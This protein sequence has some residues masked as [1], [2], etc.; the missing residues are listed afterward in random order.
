MSSTPFNEDEAKKF[1]VAQEEKEKERIETIRKAVLQTSITILKEEFQNS[2]VEVY[3]VGSILQP[4]QF[5]DRSDIDIVLK[6]FQGDYF[7]TWSKLSMKFDRTIE[8]I[9]FEQ[10]HFQDFILKHGLKVV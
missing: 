4:F 5:Q 1:L 2:P 6:N 9:L 8:V 3:L 10:C 7:E